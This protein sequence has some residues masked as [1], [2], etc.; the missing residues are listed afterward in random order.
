M[1]PSLSLP[2]LS[3]LM[4]EVTGR[5]SPTPLIFLPLSRRSEDIVKQWDSVTDRS[6]AEK[7]WLVCGVMGDVMP[8]D[9]ERYIYTL[10]RNLML[11]SILKK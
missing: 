9:R 1:F 11:V 10:D 6:R 4:S 2:F 5:L 7:L 8:C 3:L